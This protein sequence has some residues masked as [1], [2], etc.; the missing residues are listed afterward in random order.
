M[1]S[2]RR[3]AA[4]AAFA[5]LLASGPALADEVD[6][7]SNAYEAT[8]RL[9]KRGELRAALR[10]AKSCAREVCPEILRQDCAAWSTSLT[11]LVP[12]ARI[13]V[14]G[15]G[16][17]VARD[18]TVHVDKKPTLAGAIELDPGAHVAGASLPSGARIERRFTLAEREKDRAIELTFDSPEAC[19]ATAPV[20]ESAAPRGPTARAVPLLSWVLGGAG[21]AALGVSGAFAWRGFSIRSDLRNAKCEP[22]C[23][24]HEVDRARSAFLVADVAGGTG[25][26]A[27]AAAVA[28]YFV[29]A[30]P[31]RTARAMLGPAGVGLGGAF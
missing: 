26:V 22:V 6:A 21:I 19:L 11:A 20:L 8:Q 7:C 24:H 28:I 25:L 12:T 17:C 29:A 3:T 9:E 13:R 15:P 27:L 23:D 4:A 16:G 5:S 2:A 18:V 10:E 31:R 1:T 14:R 30:G